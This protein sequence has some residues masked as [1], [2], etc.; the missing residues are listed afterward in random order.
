M[1]LPDQPQEQKS[2]TDQE[3]LKQQPPLEVKSMQK[4][5]RDPYSDD[6]Y[7]YD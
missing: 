6:E 1:D 2:I 5:P 3:E 7:P 4:P